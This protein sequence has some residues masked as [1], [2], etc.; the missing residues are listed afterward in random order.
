MAGT[1][2][3]PVDF[4]TWVGVMGT[5]LGA[6]MA[7]VDIQITNSSLRDITGGI[8][9]TQDEGSWISTSYLIGEIVTI[10][11]TAW[12]ARVFSPRWYLIVNVALFLIFSCLCGLARSLGEMIAFR[13][14]QGFTGGVMIPMALTTALSTL[15]KSKQPLGLALF[16]ITATLGPAIGPSIGG[17]LTDNYGW[18]WVFYVN[19]IPGAVMISSIIYAV[20]SAPMQLEQLRDGDWFGI[21]CMAIGLGSLIAMLEEGQRDD[22]LGSPFIQRCAILAA[23]FI[24]AF[25]IIELLRKKPFVNLRLIGSRNLGIASAAN[26]FLGSALYGTVYLLPQYLTIVQGYSAFQT[27]EAMIWVGIPQLLVFPFVPRLMKRFDLRAL[28]CFGTLVFAFS[29]WMN[30]SMS[31]DYAGDQFMISN[32]IRAL[33]Q[34][35]TIVPLSALATAILL[36]KDAGDGS[37]VF[38]IARNL[39]GS[40]GTAVLDTVITR[41]EQFHDFEIGA[42]IN[43]Y[44]PVVQDRLNNIA[45]AFVNKGHDAV[46]AT[47][48]AYGQL[49]NI[50]RREAYVMAFNDAFLIV[51][52][53]LL[54]AAVLVW[55]CKKTTAKAGMA[56]H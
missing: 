16:G 54:I 35:F 3:K 38:N 36:P 32:I 55:L 14:F 44:R 43:S 19:L 49:K 20:R 12:L 13:A 41:R 15:P 24:P 25:V 28:V 56:A 27:G 29:C 40:V 30:S 21:G 2:E 50:V 48:Q 26:F 9:A 18:Q 7:V 52:I 4:R 33:G 5:M 1:E 53:S 11:L 51:G 45:V 10:P 6:F 8:S 22:W 42:Y 17:W 23:I 39:G 37:A 47:Q 46:A 31:H 34:P